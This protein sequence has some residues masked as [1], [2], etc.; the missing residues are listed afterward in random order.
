MAALFPQWVESVRTYS[1]LDG[2]ADNPEWRGLVERADEVMLRLMRVPAAT[3]EDMAIKSY[4]AI[5]HEL[6][7]CRTEFDID[8]SGGLMTDATPHRALIA[9][10]VRLSPTLA[11]AL[12]HFAAG[13]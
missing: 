4:L 6:G 3:V 8:F 9:D 5:R 12:A 10:A 11:V 7:P 2:E 1:A 13:V